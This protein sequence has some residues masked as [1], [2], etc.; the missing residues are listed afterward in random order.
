MPGERALLLFEPRDV[1]VAEHG[2]AVGR[3]ADDLIDGVSETFAGL[4]G[5]AVDE[6]DVDAVEAEFAGE[7]NEV[8]RRFIALN[9]VD[10]FLDIVLKILNAHRQA[11]EAHA[12]EYFEVRAGGDARI[13]LNADF[14]VVAEGEALARVREKLFDLRRR[15]ISRSAATPMELRDGTRARDAV[16]HTINLFFQCGEV[17]WR[18]AFVFLDD[19]VAGAEE[20]ETLAKGKM[21]VERDGRGIALSLFDGGF[22]I[23]GAESVDPDRSGGIAGVA[24]AGAIVTIDELFGDGEFL[25]HLAKRGFGYGHKNF[26][27]WR[28]RARG[29]GRANVRKRGLLAGMDEELRVFHGRVLQNAVAEIEDVAVSAEFGSKIES[30]PADF[31]LRAEE[32]RRVQIALQ[33]NMW[34]GEGAEL[35]EGNTPV[36]TEYVRAGFHD[37][38]KQVVGGFRVVDDR[39]GAAEAGND[40]LN[41]R[42]NEFGVI[43]EV[44]LAAPGIEKLHGGDASGNLRLEVK[45]SGFGDALKKFAKNAGL[46][47][48]EILYGRKAF[49]GAAFDHVAREGPGR[50]GEAENGDLRTCGPDGAAKSFHQKTGFGFGIEDAKFFYVRRRANGFGKIR[51][52]VFKFECE[53]HRFGGDQNIREDD[54]GVYAKTAEGLQ[55]DFDGEIGGL[56]DFQER[57]LCAELAI[58]R[59]VAAGLAH[60]PNG[61]PG[62]RLASAGAEKEFFP[63]ERG[64]SLERHSLG[65]RITN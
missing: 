34:T 25:L 49:L 6:I 40:L 62:N 14:G 45:N 28:L 26:L 33:R 63:S 10:S 1:G 41:G 57:V 21:H 16:G 50:S 30:A 42:E 47:I 2:D 55:G 17:R 51:A 19:D 53:P 20:A 58:F 37:S 12:A 22:E 9:A 3:K 18:N 24:R 8:A 39:N 59:K 27:L 48:E 29:N 35:T 56:A 5:K 23:G 38:R 54:D 65:R 61:E 43:T 15:Q 13:D 64:G 60:H 4:I 32:N 52:F 46:F 31:F 7:K 44:E 36:D 11:V